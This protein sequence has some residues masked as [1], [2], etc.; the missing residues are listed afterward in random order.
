MAQARLK[1]Y[2]GDLIYCNGHI[3]A[4][5]GVVGTVGGPPIGLYP[6][7][8]ALAAVASCI[9]SSPP[10]RI[11]FANTAMDFAASSSARTAR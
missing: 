1:P 2:D 3:L 9:T 6:N 5:P 10:S 8:P 4:T 11:I 7:P